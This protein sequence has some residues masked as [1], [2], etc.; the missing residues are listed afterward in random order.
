ML[1]YLWAFMIIIGVVF[2]V[3]NGKIDLV[4]NAALDSSKEAVTLCITMLGIMSFWTGLMQ[5]AKAAGIIDALT[6]KLR[7][8]LHFLFPSIPKDHVANEYIAANMIANLLGLGWAAT[9]MGLKAMEELR[10]LNHDSER[11][12]VDMCTFLI[13]NISS[14]ELI[15]IN[16]IAYRSQ[17]GSVKP[18]AILFAAIIATTCS[19]LTGILFAKIMGRRKG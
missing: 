2:G 14:L 9:P 1:N 18:T 6:K 8:L 19:T 5:V 12:S 7:P 13:V 4:S 17:Y 11:A 15:P 3:C 16:I 10:K